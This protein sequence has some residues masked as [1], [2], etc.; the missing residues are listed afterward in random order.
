MKSA[1]ALPR[2]LGV[3]C[4]NP[5]APGTRL[6]FMLTRRSLMRFAAALPVAFAAI[7]AWAFSSK[8]FW[9]TK[10]SSDWN[11]EEVDRMITKSPWAKEVA[12]TS[13]SRIGRPWKRRRRTFARRHRLPRWWY[14]FSGRGGGYP[15][16]YPGGGNRGGYPGGGGYP[17]GG[18]GVIP[19][20]AAAAS[21]RPRHCSLGIGSPRFRK[22][23]ICMPTTKSPTPT[24]KNTT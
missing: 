24:S 11:S 4:R 19:E 2:P 18:G 7:P 14:W 8:D 9:E 16:G 20:A 13:G 17:R 21:P 6:T 3:I 22:R 10:P 1:R 5:P 23:C 12:I 15:G